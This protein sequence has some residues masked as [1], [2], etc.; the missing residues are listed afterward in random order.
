V[1]DV[2]V[3]TA[4][5]ESFLGKLSPDLVRALLAGGLRSEYPPG[6]TIYRPNATS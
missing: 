3:V 4:M 1:A 6:T 2:D 5:E